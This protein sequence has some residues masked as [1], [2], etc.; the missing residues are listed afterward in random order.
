VVTQLGCSD[1]PI[2]PFVS[3]S[4]LLQS[5]FAVNVLKTATEILYRMQLQ[6]KPHT[7]KHIPSTEQWISSISTKNKPYIHIMLYGNYH[8]IQWNTGITTH[9]EPFYGSLDFVW[10]NPGEP[11]PEET[12]THWNLSWSSIVPHLLHPSN[13]IYDILP[14]QSMWLIVFFHNLLPS[15]HK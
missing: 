11:V 15:F 6:P 10:D 14:V 4:C 5:L 8:C 1:W 3:V 9:T 13:T 7:Y 12:F 2:F